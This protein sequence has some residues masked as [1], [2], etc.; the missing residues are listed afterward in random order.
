MK[1]LLFLLLPLF[2][3]GQMDSVNIKYVQHVKDYRD[4][5]LT[6]QEI[7]DVLKCIDD[8][9]PQYSR[10]LKLEDLS[11]IN[12][13]KALIGDYQSRCNHIIKK[14]TGNGLVLFTSKD[15][16]RKYIILQERLLKSHASNKIIDYWL[17]QDKRST[18]AL[19]L[20]IQNN[21]KRLKINL[22]DWEKMSEND[23]KLLFSSFQ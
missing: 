15:N 2:V 20:H 14:E 4:L 21:L 1:N 12:V 19:N 10:L 8:F 13:Q 7:E 5:K 6:T 18:S 9:V 3:F 23:R 22:S 17:E 16:V 11:N